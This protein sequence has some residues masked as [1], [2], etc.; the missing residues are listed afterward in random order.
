VVNGVDAIQRARYRVPIPHVA[1]LEL[2][3]IGEVSRPFGAV[4]VDL[5][6]QVVESPNL[7]AM[8][9]EFVGEVRPDETRTACD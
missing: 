8:L 5:W 2:D 7:V 9:E 6:S 1:D 3:V 4:A